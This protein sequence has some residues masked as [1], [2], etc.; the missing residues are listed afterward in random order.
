M[1]KASTKPRLPKPFMGRIIVEAIHEELGEFL[2]EKAGLDKESELAKS[3]FEIV[4][5][6]V[7]QVQGEYID[8]SYEIDTGLKVPLKKGKIIDMAPDAFGPAFQ[9]RYGPGVEVLKIGDTV[10]FIPMQTYKLDPA[11]EYHLIADQDVLAYYRD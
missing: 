6:K 2:A 5:A 8:S 7:K 9:N 11:G 3:G 10:M 4:A 1:I